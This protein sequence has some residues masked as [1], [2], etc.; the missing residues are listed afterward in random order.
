[1]GN[2]AQGRGSRAKTTGTNRVKLA[3]KSLALVRGQAEQ[4][5]TGSYRL[6]SIGNHTVSSSIWN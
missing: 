2:L 6:I 4:V 5:R 1:M 3:Y